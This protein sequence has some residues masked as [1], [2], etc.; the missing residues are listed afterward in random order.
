VNGVKLD[1]FTMGLALTTTVD[2]GLLGIGFPDNEA[3]VATGDILLHP[4]FVTAVVAAGDISSAAY[5]LWLDDLREF[6][7]A[8]FP[9][10][11]ETK[12]LQ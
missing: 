6:S 3:G 1:N 5:S 11:I 2:I 4:T 8:H 12:L 9:P 10:A 7:F